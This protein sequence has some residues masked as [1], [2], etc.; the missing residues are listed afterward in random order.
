MR[1]L[2]A[3]NSVSVDG[4]FTDAGDM[5]WAHKGSDDPEYS[6]F[7]GGN[8]SGG[9]QLVF[10]RITYDM[11]AAYWPTPLAKQNNPVV[12]EGM[13]RMPK[14]VFSRTMDR[15]AWSNTTVVK[16]DLAKAIADLKNT[17]GDDMAILGSG[18]IVAQLTSAGLIDEYQIVVCPIILGKG[19]TLFEGVQ[20]RLDL[21]LT[22]SR[23]FRNG[24]VF[25]CY[26]RG[27]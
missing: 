8:A 17:P 18:S 16:G 25:Q 10:G 9:G 21:K 23:T 27:A 2:V 20:K 24:K 22:K 12:A 13:N 3:F 4:Y 6:A 19:R 11:M 15:S 7:V 1:K 5:T 26:E 14:V